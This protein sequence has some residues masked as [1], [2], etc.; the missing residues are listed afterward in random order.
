MYTWKFEKLTSMRDMVVQ[1]LPS[2]IQVCVYVCMCK[3]I[4]VCIN[5]YVEV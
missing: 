3:C 2:P 4:F 5:V 1:M